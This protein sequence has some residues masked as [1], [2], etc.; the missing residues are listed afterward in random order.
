M[1]IEDM[2]ASHTTRLILLLLRH[3]LNPQESPPRLVT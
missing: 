1:T 3:F 2:V